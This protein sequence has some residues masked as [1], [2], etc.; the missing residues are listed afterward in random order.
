M[1]LVLMLGYVGC[2]A[3][4]LAVA[5][6]GWASGAFF[7]LMLS[8]A[9]LGLLSFLTAALPVQLGLERLERLERVS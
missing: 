6:D 3:W 7:E 9:A 8:S 5:W 2:V 1:V 4:A